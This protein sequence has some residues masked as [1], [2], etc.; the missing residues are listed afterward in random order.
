V[1]DEDSEVRSKSKTKSERLVDK[2][3]ALRGLQPCR[4][5]EACIEVFEHLTH[6]ARRAGAYQA[7]TV[8]KL[9]GHP[10]ASADE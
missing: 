5:T 2:G 10:I 6:T 3:R 1:L 9:D 4:R 7:V 8:E